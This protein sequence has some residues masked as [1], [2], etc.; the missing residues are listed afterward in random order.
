[1]L[2][3]D[4]DILIDFIRGYKPAYSFFEKNKRIV[5]IS[6]LSKFEIIA[7]AKDQNKII[8]LEEFLSNFSVLTL[9]NEIIESA[10]EI[11]K[12]SF[13]TNNMSANDALIAATSIYFKFPLVSR[14]K[15]HYSKIEK[16]ELI[17]PY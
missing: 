17:V 14:N 5:F 2:L 13:L 1:M 15:K 11:F 12:T 10:Y 16:L 8:K 3:I 9:S 4:S 7:G 6:I